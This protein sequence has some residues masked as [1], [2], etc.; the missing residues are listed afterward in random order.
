MLEIFVISLEDPFVVSNFSFIFIL[1]IRQEVAMAPEKSYK[2]SKWIKVNAK[3]MGR[4]W[5]L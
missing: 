3:K 2:Y 1:Y 4:K 5:L